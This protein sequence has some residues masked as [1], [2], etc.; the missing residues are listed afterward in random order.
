MMLY[1]AEFKFKFIETPEEIAYKPVI[2]C[3]HPL[4]LNP[5]YPVTLSMFIS[6]KSSFFFSVMQA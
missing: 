5:Y 3:G 6:V 1:D 2:L 4:K